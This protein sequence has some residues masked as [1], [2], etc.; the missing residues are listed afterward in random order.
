MIKF[1]L[2]ANKFGLKLESM[3]NTNELWEIVCFIGSN[4]AGDPVSRR[5]VSGFILN[6][7]GAP[8]SW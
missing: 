7:V 3:G 4:N 8:V 6:M 5:S 1:V 2:N